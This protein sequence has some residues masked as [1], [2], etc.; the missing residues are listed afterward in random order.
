[1][2]FTLI[3][4]KSSICDTIA[5]LQVSRHPFGNQHIWCFLLRRRLT[6]N[7]IIDFAGQVD[8][9]LSHLSSSPGVEATICQTSLFYLN[10]PRFP[11]KHKRAPQRSTGPLAVGRHSVMAHLWDSNPEMRLWGSPS[12]GPDLRRRGGRR[13]L[14]VAPRLRAPRGRGP[15]PPRGP[16]P[17]G[18]EPVPAGARAATGARAPLPLLRPASGTQPA[19]L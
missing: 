11:E 13:G 16:T 19:L 7:G 2:L 8:R 1:M 9:V 17:R 14:P 5:S 6:A 18:R 3:W 10:L 15:S 4:T 12:C